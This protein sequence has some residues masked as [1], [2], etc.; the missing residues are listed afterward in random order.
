MRT[1]GELVEFLGD[2]P[3]VAAKKVMSATTDSMGMIHLDAKNQPGVYNLLQ[4]L[5]LLENKPLADV[6]QEWEGNKRYGDLKKAVATE[7]EAFLTE[8]QQRLATIDEVE[9]M[10]KMLVS[11]KHMTKQASATLLRAQQAVGLREL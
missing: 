3:A 4:I 11:E 5:A 6:A 1:S 9:V 10:T 7:V 2:D 8:F